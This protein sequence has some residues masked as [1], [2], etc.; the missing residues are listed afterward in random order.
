MIRNK[1][2]QFIYKLLDRQRG[3]TLLELLVVIGI[4]AVTSGFIYPQIG[5]WKI[6]RNV[7]KDFQAVASTIDYLKL[8]SLTVNGTAELDCK[9]STTGGGEPT[10]RYI[11]SSKRNNDGSFNRPTDFALNII[12]QSGGSS[13]TGKVDVECSHIYTIFNAS[14]S[15]GERGSSGT[16]LEVIISYK[17]D[18]VSD[19]NKY[20]AYKIRVNTATAFVQ[21]S[22]YD[23]ASGTWRELN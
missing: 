21:K 16:A 8:R 2:N 1:S 20:N 17:V 4:L 14:G 11:V 15:A 10:L 6:K 7:E 19:F 3:F 9:N 12:E 18:G 5:H 23:I 22:K 13:I